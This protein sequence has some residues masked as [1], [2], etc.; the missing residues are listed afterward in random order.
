L[1]Q[2]ELDVLALALHGLQT[3][4]VLLQV[5]QDLLGLDDNGDRL[6]LLLVLAELKLKPRP[7]E[8]ERIDSE[9]RKKVIRLVEGK[10]REV[11][12]S[13]ASRDLRLGK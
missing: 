10:A 7:L 9:F 8:G 2:E 11:S 13:V 5:G 1:V 6:T 12:N 4:H 3:G